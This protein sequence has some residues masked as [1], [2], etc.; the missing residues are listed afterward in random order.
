MQVFSTL[1]D[2]MNVNQ[3]RMK[4]DLTRIFQGQNIVGM[5]AM[6]WVFVYFA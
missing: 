4:Y 2:M 1:P 3:T 6:N 5:S